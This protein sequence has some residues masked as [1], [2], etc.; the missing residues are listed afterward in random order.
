MTD[1]LIRIFVKNHKETNDPHVRGAYG[2]LSSITGI[3][4]NVMLFVMK[5]VAGVFVGSVSVIADA[6]NNLAD[7]S[8]SVISLIGFRLS[9]RPADKDHPYGHGRYEYIAGLVV[10]MTIIIIG[11][12]LLREAVEKIIHQSEVE[13]G[14]FTFVILA[15]SILVKLWMAL[16]YKKTGKAISS[17]TLLAAAADSRND[18]VS[19]F[20]VLAGAAVTRFFGLHLDGWLGV[21]VALFIIVSGIRSAKDTIDPVLGKAPDAEMVEDIRRRIMRYDGVLGT[22]D[23]MVHDYGV[24][25]RFASVHVE[26]SAEGD[27]IENHEV[28]DEIERDFLENDGIHM[29]VHFDPVPSKDSEL[30]DLREWITCEIKK[31]DSRITIHDLR[32]TEDCVS[33]DC[34]I[35]QDMDIGDKEITSFIENI[36]AAKYPSHVCDVSI[37][38]GFTEIAD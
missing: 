6:V 37:D 29:I 28:I 17:K 25:H 19:T 7:A 30:G 26:M 31:L 21:L 23:L 32:M 15:V 13:F 11:A 1:L 3:I 5:I 24:G 2:H 14:V 22:H 4:C 10:S 27:A 18:V 33:L 8:S 35:P 20:A 34:A 9:G 36:V 38:R 16:F 12:G